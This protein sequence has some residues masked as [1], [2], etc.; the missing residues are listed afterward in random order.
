MRNR[1]AKVIFIILAFNATCINKSYGYT[2]RRG[3]IQN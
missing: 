1:V 3:V 2:K